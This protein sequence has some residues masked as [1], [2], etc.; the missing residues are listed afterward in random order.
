MSSITPNPK[1]KEKVDVT[2]EEYMRDMYSGVIALAR[3]LEATIGEEKTKEILGRL[4]LKEFTEW[5]RDMVRENPINC[6][7][8]FTAM[9]RRVFGS[10]RSHIMEITEATPTSYREKDTSCIFAK[11]CRDLDAADLGYVMFC[12]TDFPLAQVFNPRLRLER[13][14]T[15]MQG[16]DCCDFHYTWRENEVA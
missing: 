3:E 5:A 4:Y 15:L 14:K 10:S 16:D 13:S 2:Y 6:M 8:D 9:N 11:L 7:E 1:W 12:A